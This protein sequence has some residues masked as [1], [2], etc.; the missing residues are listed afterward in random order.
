MG[1]RA[2]RASRAWAR[3]ERGSNRVYRGGGW[4]NNA[5]NLRAANRNRNDPSNR[6]N[7]LGFRLAR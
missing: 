2:V 7:D 4:N 1:Y 3:A 6:N 5:S